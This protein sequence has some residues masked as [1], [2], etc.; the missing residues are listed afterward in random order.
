MELSVPDVG[1]APAAT[2]VREVPGAF[3]S[4]GRSPASGAAGD[5][6]LPEPVVGAVRLPAAVPGGVADGGGV[7]FGVPGLRGGVAW[8]GRTDDGAG[9][10]LVVPELLVDAM[11]PDFGAVELC[12]PAEPDFSAAVVPELGPVV[13][14]DDAGPVLCIDAELVTVVREPGPEVTVLCT[15]LPDGV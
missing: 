3:G 13:L 4:A 12:D 8:P 1:W 5:P 6:G 15:A 11:V 7:G 14:P 9:V 10:G 2:E